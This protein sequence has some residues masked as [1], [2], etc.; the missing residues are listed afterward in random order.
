MPLQ[1]VLLDFEPPE[2][3]A[4]FYRS[5]GDLQMILENNHAARARKLRL[6]MRLR[7]WPPKGTSS[8]RA[9]TYTTA[10]LSVNLFSPSS[11]S[12]G[13]CRDRD[14]PDHHGAGYDACNS[15]SRL[16]KFF[17]QVRNAASMSPHFL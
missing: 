16:R 2:Q 13:R 1:L 12:F 5:L 17:A 4:R 14:L 9:R 8:K 6:P 3:H 10:V 11:G 7:K 15:S